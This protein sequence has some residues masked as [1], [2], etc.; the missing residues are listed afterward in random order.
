MGSLHSATAV[1]PGHRVIVDLGKTTFLDASGVEALLQ[2]GRGAAR[3]GVDYRIVNAQALVRS[4][5]DHCG[6]PV[7]SG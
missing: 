5:L 6:V 2:G 3:R 7:S 1:R 4:V